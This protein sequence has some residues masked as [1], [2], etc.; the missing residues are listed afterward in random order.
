MLNKH[1]FPL[2]FNKFAQKSK[3]DLETYLQEVFFILLIVC[4]LIQLYFLLNNHLKLSRTIKDIE[5]PEVTIPVSVIISARNE[6]NNLLTNLPL[7]LQQKYPDYEVIVVNDSSYDD[8]ENILL[9]LKNSYNHLKIVT[10]AIN[11]KY[12]TGKKFAL[13]LGIKAAKNEHLLFSDADCIPASSDWITRMVANFEPGKEIILGY[14][15]YNRTK[16]IINPLIRFETIKTAINYFSAALKGKAYMGI[17]RNLAYTKTLFF[18]NKGFASHMHVLSGD[19]DIFV[20]E[21][22]TLTNVAIET[23][24]DSFMYSIPKTTFGDWFNQ[25]RRHFGAGKFYKGQHKALI[26]LDAITGL[27]YYISLAAC[28]L[29]NFEPYIVLGVFLGRYLLQILIYRKLFKQFKGYYFLFYLP[30]LDILYYFYL[31]IFGM[32]AAFTRNKKWK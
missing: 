12:R 4:L 16:N 7:I 30:L 18:N 28:L 6:S 3:Q 10:V 14:S 15:P 22:A 19:D 5:I 11:D 26:S 23:H 27:F 9:E 31:N 29:L 25:K 13:T 2:I 20:N 17:G 8:S 32:I 24:P 21:N 1:K